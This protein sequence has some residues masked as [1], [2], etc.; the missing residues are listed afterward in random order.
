MVIIKRL[1]F[2]FQEKSY[3]CGLACLLMVARYYNCNVSRDYLEKVSMAT[4]DGTTM[5]GL[6][7]AAFSLG[8]EAIGK[9]GSI[10]DIKKQLLP[11]IAHVKINNSNN[12]YHYVVI[13]NISRNKVT[14]KDPSFGN[15]TMSKE[16]FSKIETGNYLFIS[17]TASIKR[18]IRRKI[19]RE[20][21]N[22]LFYSNKNSFILI[23]ISTVF[24]IILELLNLF[25]LKVILNNALIVKSVYNLSI[26]LLVFAYL[27]VLKTFLSYLMQLLVLK[28]SKIFSFNLKSNLIK[29]LLSLPNLYYQTKERGIMVSLFN[30]VDILTESLL[31][32]LST[33]ISSIVILIFIYIFFSSL[34]YFLTIV[35]L[36]SSIFLFLFIY[37]QK[38]I[39]KS[40]ISKYYL[41]KDSYDSK[42]QQVIIN[43]DKVKGLHLE[44][45]MLKKIRKVT[46][47]KENE[48]YNIT[49]YGEIIKSSLNFLEGI[50]YLIILGIS[51]VILISSTSMSLPTFLLLEGFI[52]MALKNVENLSLI[53]LKY[54]NIKKICERLNNIFNLEKEVLLPFHNYDYVTNNMSIV[55]SKLSFRYKDNVILN[56]INLKINPKDKVFIYGDSGSGKSTLVKLLGR[57]LPLEFGHIKLGNIDLT[58]YNLADLR[59]IITYVSNREMLS[60]G[61]IKDNIYLSRKPRLNQ[62]ILLQV[63][64]VKKIL[65]EKKY[66]LKTML[67]ENGENISMGERSRISLA[68]ALFKPSEIYILD[69]CL[70]NVDID[71][72]REIVEK[73]LSYYKDKI[74]IY[75]SH[76]LNNKDLFNRVFYLEKGKCYEEL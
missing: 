20:E 66:T 33:F 24:V 2:I 70:S 13:T 76:R 6:M 27:L 5:Y 10:N 38:K 56:N 63:T 47:I 51:G 30:D 52:F 15:R 22:K 23:I 4:E 43:N 75:I 72:E 28:L 74:V 61:N 11:I 64:G 29:Q 3:D 55:I 59:N 9:N 8:F 60:R 71:L 40:L 17:K 36:T 12:L 19:I 31:S 34:S 42:L 45:L 16:E 69:E 44:D 58:H 68:Q 65:K 14:I 18:F 57:F 1:K 35:L 39:S 48:S 49:K 62:D 53:V 67:S 32:S 41:I 25:S 37:L 54:Q 7:K 50:I 26:L 46:S 73:L 21:F